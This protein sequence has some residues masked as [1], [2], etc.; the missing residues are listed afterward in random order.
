MSE[1]WKAAISRRF[2]KSR[3]IVTNEIRLLPHAGVDY[4]CNLRLGPAASTMVKAST[5]STSEATKAALIAGAAVV[6]EGIEAFRIQLMVDPGLPRIGP[7][8]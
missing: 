7:R 3:R 1:V 5:T 8:D 2:Q 6:K 4:S